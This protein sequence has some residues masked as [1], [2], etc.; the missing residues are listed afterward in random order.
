M[1]IEVYEHGWKRDHLEREEIIDF[2][3]TQS[4][5]T[6]KLL[7]FPP[8]DNDSLDSVKKRLTDKLSKNEKLLEKS[9]VLK[10]R[11][12][13]ELTTLANENA[14]IRKEILKTLKEKKL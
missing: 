5:E 14:E 11:I 1:K 8:D 6:S 4:F 2:L 13:I 9:Q 3:L 7:V 12:I 10:K